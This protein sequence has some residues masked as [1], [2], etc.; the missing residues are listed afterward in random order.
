MKKILSYEIL[1]QQRNAYDEYVH[2]AVEEAKPI[3]SILGE[4]SNH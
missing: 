3:F 1:R 2:G 4:M